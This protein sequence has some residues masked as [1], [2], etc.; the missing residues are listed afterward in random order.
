MHVGS[1]P[2]DA[3]ETLIDRAGRT[4]SRVCP[5]RFEIG[6]RFQDVS[7]GTSVTCTRSEQRYGRLYFSVVR[8]ITTRKVQR[9]VR[10]SFTPF[11]LS[12]ARAVRTRA[13]A[14]TRRAWRPSYGATPAARATRSPPVAP[15]EPAGPISSCMA[16]LDSSWAHDQASGCRNGLCSGCLAR[17]T[18]GQ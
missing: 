13:A 6:V 17:V 5:V 8:C 7:K 1:R 4:G 11:A 10:T 18:A 16:Q 12:D 15:C 3:R 14:R 2:G 9:K